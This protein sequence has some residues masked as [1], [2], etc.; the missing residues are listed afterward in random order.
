MQSTGSLS[1]SQKPATELYPDE[2]GSIP[3]TRCRYRDNIKMDFRKMVVKMW[4]DPMS[5]FCDDGD[6][7]LTER[8]FLTSWS[9]VLYQPSWCWWLGQQKPHSGCTCSVPLVKALG[10]WACPHSGT[11]VKGTPVCAALWDTTFHEGLLVNLTEKE[12]TEL[13]SLMN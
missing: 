8:N 10:K 12:T 4:K 2:D 1:C 7:S 3:Q 13:P 11:G 6:E 5:G 9:K